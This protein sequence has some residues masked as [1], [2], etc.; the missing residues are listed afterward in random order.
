[1]QY[2]ACING[3]ACASDLQHLFESEATL[4]NAALPNRL[5]LWQCNNV[6]RSSGRCRGRPLRGR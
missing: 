1:M 3:I 5:Q 2:Q 4:A 6:Q